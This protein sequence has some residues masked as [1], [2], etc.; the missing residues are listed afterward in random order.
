MANKTL[1]N[2]HRALRTLELVVLALVLAVVGAHVAVAFSTRRMLTYYA[3]I[4][5]SASCQNLANEL[6]WL[7]RHS[8]LEVFEEAVVFV[9]HLHNY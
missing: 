7:D 1:I 4:P 5:S 6:Y 8:L 9:L 2:R 3:L